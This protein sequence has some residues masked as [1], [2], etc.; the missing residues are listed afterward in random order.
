MI[1]QSHSRFRL[2]NAVARAPNG[3]WKEDPERESE[4]TGKNNSAKG[5]HDG[6]PRVGIFGKLGRR[7]SIEQQRLR[8]SNSSSTCNNLLYI[9][10]VISKF[11]EE[12]S[13]KS[14]YMI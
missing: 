9:E 3:Y 8:C 5:W 4:E 1:S 2:T 13:E 12:G 6:P 11:D 7:D 10:P 14:I